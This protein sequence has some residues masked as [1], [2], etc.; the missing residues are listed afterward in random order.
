MKL[1]PNP[2]YETFLAE[3]KKLSR[4]F[5]KHKGFLFRAS[6]LPY[7]N[8]ARLLDG[9]GSL[10]HGGRWSAA[11]TFPASNLS[12]TPEAAFTE[13]GANYTYYNFASSDVRPKITVAVRARFSNVIDLVAPKGIRAKP[14]LELDQLL[15]EDWRKVNDKK[16]ESQSQAFGRAARDVGA[17]ALLVPSAR[18][19]GGMNVVYFPESLAPASKVEILGEAELSRWLKTP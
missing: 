13:S 8:A 9:R 17:E 14:W 19:P 2:R 18:A 10:Q 4:L 11:R 1:V 15:V 6:P 12:T 16:Q 5:S 3:L 7:A